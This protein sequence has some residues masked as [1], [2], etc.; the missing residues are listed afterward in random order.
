MTR[1]ARRE[2]RSTGGWDIKIK[3]RTINIYLASIVYKCETCLGDLV[4][5]NKGLRCKV[6]PDHRGFIHRDEAKD[7]EIKQ[8]QHI[9][10]LSEIYVVKDGK[11]QLKCQS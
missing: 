9:T 5:H 3:G 7:I 11:V 2:A 4:R 6:N 10:E 8:Q 1:L